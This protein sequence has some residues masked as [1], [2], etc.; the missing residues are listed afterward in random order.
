MI[1]Q[2][3][4]KLLYKVRINTNVFFSFLFLSIFL[5]S[6]AFSA[7]SKSSDD[8]PDKPTYSRDYYKAIKLIRSE[9]FDEA[10]IILEN[11]VQRKPNDANIHNYMGFSF[12]KKGMLEKSA[13]HYERALDIDPRHL[14]ALEYQGE[15]YILLGNIEKAKEN[16][17]KIDDICWNECTEMKE[18]KEA[19]QAAK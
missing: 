16:L 8:K 17:E 19:I 14:G 5:F 9:S 1:L 15:L 18:L 10:L 7:G 12:R 11:I 6:P 2:H 3:K 13:Y 4:F